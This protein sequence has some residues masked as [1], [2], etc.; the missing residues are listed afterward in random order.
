MQLTFFSEFLLSD[1][2]TGF[3][4]RSF[5]GDKIDLS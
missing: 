5:W 2:L 4:S 1:Y 3:Q